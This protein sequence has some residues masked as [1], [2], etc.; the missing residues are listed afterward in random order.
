M[1]WAVGYDESWKRD[2]GYGVPAFCD[3]PGCEK[4]INRG[5]GYVC[6]GDEP[7]G[8]EHGC[9]RFFCADHECAK[10]NGDDRVCGHAGIED[11][12]SDDHPDWINYKLTDITWKAWRDL[13]PEWVSAQPEQED[14]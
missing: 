12:I 10:W 1:S 6:C 4:E 9:G 11:H 3:Y 7:Y 13:N 14:T 2:I 5:L 8:G